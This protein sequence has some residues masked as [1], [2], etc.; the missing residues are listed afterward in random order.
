MSSHIFRTYDCFANSNDAWAPLNPGPADLRPIWQIATATAAAPDYFDPAKIDSQ[1]FADGGISANNPTQEALR[2]LHFL[3][4]GRLNDFCV[5]SIGSGSGIHTKVSKVHTRPWK[6]LVNAA[7]Q[8]IAQTESTHETVADIL[9]M[10]G[11]SYFRMNAD[12]EIDVRLDEW[13][14]LEDVATFTR[15]YLAHAEVNARLEECA[16]NLVQGLKLGKREP[17]NI[18]FSSDAA[19]PETSSKASS[20]IPFRRDPDFVDHGAILDQ[21]HQKCASPASRTALVGLGGVG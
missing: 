17:S 20:T 21:L 13:Q 16:N 9:Q 3:H 2:E 10:S 4:D 12:L 8:M 5:V 11:G 14:K 19:R 6:V 7:R 18:D 1:V 15:R